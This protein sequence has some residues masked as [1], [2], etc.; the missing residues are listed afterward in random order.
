MYHKNGK[1]ITK[2]NDFRKTISFRT[3]F[4]TCIHYP[5]LVIPCHLILGFLFPISTCLSIYMVSLQAKVP[6]IPSFS[7]VVAIVFLRLVT[8]LNSIHSKPTS[9]FPPLELI[10]VL[11]CFLVLT[12]PFLSIPL[13]LLLKFK[14]LY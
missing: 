8:S 10:F 5:H 6:H 3:S 1:F 7:F 4:S 12:P 14:T 2:L 13:S 11:F 9:F